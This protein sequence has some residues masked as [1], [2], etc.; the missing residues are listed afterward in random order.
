MITTQRR[1]A[2]LTGASLSALGV[3]VLTATPALAAPHDTLGTGSYPGIHT[4]DDTIVI[5]DLAVPGNSTVPGSPCFFGQINRAGGPAIVSG[6][7]LGEIY[8]YVT[9]PDA[10]ASMANGAGS[11]AEVGAIS[12]GGPAGFAHIFGPAIRQYTNGTTNDAV[13]TINNA[14]NLLI[15]AYATGS[16]AANAGIGTGIRQTATAYDSAVANINNAAGANLNIEAIAYATSTEG[17]NALAQFASEGGAGII[18]VVNGISASANVVNAGNIDIGALAQAYGTAAQARALGGEALVQDVHASGSYATAAGAPGDAVA[19]LTNDGLINIHATASATAYG[20]GG[21][22]FA[23]AGFFVGVDQDVVADGGNATA[24]IANG[25]T[26]NVNAVANATAAHGGALAL[27]LLGR[28]IDQAVTANATATGTFGE[29]YNTAA[30]FGDANASLTNGGTINV[31]VAANATAYFTGNA[32]ALMA[33]GIHQ[34]ANANTTTVGTDASAVDVGGNATAYMTNA[35]DGTINI[36]AVAVANGGAGGGNASANAGFLNGIVQNANAGAGDAAATLLNDG[37]IN[38]VAAA[39]AHAM[40]QAV[41]RPGGFSSTHVATPFAHATAAFADGIDQSANAGG[42]T[43]GYFTVVGAPGPYGTVVGTYAYN[44]ADNASALLTNSGSINI[45]AD[46][47]ATGAHAVANASIGLGFPGGTGDGIH[48]GAHATA[49]TAATANVSLTNTAYGTIAVGAVATAYGSVDGMANANVDRGIF[50]S[51]DANVEDGTAVANAY[52][53]NAGVITVGASAHASAGGP[54]V[55][56]N[57]NTGVA[58]ANAHVGTGIRQ[59]A[60]ASGFGLATRATGVLTTEGAYITVD[61]VTGAGLANAELHNTGSIAVIANAY[62]TGGE[63]NADASIHNGINQIAR[64]AGN[65]GP[66]ACVDDQRSLRHHGSL[67]QRCCLGHFRS[68]S[69]GY[70]HRHPPGSVRIRHR[71]RRR[72]ACLRNGRA[73][74][75]RLDHGSGQRKRQRCSRDGSH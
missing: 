69:R 36:G 21:G 63:A 53:T 38:I 31:G 13:G 24:N 34:S 9:A 45:A 48:Q 2:L 7:A 70:R 15:D 44:G 12:V 20:S 33:T 27:G 8:Q 68:G 39:T 55:F 6:P 46:A 10:S 41:V 58:N 40:D 30:A 1:I 11:S 4:A 49:G 32:I 3:S 47:V 37:A 62:A 25:G 71:R 18:Q 28:G 51:A 59:V 16:F 29:S 23:Q 67:R 52:L 54:G 17:A 60:T 19:N 26:L 5:C 74:Q 65:V 72:R 61:T 75:C 66:R 73:E 22:A 43:E 50:Q 35:A 42:T 64:A 14:G 57:T 56:G